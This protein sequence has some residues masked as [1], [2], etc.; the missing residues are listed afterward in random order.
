MFQDR[1]TLEPW[2]WID[3]IGN[4]LEQTSPADASS[5]R[6]L[7]VMYQGQRT[8]Q[9]RDAAGFPAENQ[10]FHVRFL[11]A[12]GNVIRTADVVSDAAGNLGPAALAQTGERTEI[13][14]NPTPLTNDEALPVVAVYEHCLADPTN[15]SARTFPGE[16]PLILPDGF[17]GAHLQ[18]LD[19]A[20][21]YAPVVV[22][23]GNPGP[24]RLRPHS[25]V[26]P[27]VDGMAT[28]TKLVEDI[29]RASGIHL[30][31]WMFDEFPMRPHD[32]DS[33]LVK[34]MDSLGRDKFRLLITKSF[35]PKVGALDGVGTEGLIAMLMLILA[36]RTPDRVRA[37]RSFYR[38]GFAGMARGRHPYH[39]RGDRYQSGF[40]GRK[41]TSRESR[42]H[43][44]MGA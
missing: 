30:A 42:I 41:H 13:N 43:E 26:E 1:M 29:R 38:M 6:S 14:W 31:G 8:V 9:V 16:P 24:A 15:D 33:S 40:V 11:N 35:Q 12:M 19:L 28:Y 5:W 17:N 3:L 37:C 4:A 2:V 10:P 7:A 21:W 34:L 25:H 23:P 22:S 44:R 39:S 27:L 20:R 18:L 32:P 36:F